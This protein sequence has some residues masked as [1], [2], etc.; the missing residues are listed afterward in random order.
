MLRTIGI[1]SREVNGFLPG[2]YNDLGGDYIVRASD[3]H[4]WVEVFFPGNGWVTFDP[5]PAGPESKRRIFSRLGQYMDWMSLS[6]NEWMI[7]YDFAHQVQMAQ[8]DAD[9][10]RGTG[11]NR[12]A[13]GLTRSSSKVA[14]GWMK[15]WQS[16]IRNFDISC[17]WR[18]YFFW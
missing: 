11:A 13:G 2:E 6:W 9:A 1:P 18:W 3:A 10:A 7:N 16:S 17:R 15:D 14:R 4:S 5:T 8:N 12:C